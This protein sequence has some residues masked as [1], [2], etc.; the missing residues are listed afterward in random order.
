MNDEAPHLAL[1]AGT[2]VHCVHRLRDGSHVLVR[3]IRKDDVEIERRFIQALSAQSRRFRF[4]G[5][6]GSPSD[7]FLRCLVDLD[8]VHDIAFVA[9]V[10]IDN[11]TREVGVARYA[12]SEDG[13][14]CECAV[15]VDDAWHGR[16]LGTLLIGHLIE[17]A[18]GQGIGEMIA[19]VAA[20]NRDMADLAESLG[21][22]G[23]G[24]PDDPSQKIYRLCL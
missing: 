7:D 1:S 23:A 20:A 6:I 4:F 18:R 13:K 16:G 24:D 8:F 14:S 17:M 9:L 11:M 21:F 15:A 19:V 2:A 5:Q 12:V 22:A 3:G 10:H